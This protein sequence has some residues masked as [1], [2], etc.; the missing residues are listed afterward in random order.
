MFLYLAFQSVHSPLQVPDQ[1]VEQYKH[2][3]D[4]NRR[5]FAG[6]VNNLNFLLSIYGDINGR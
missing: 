6:N 3:K 1:Y 5:K 4:M 2:I